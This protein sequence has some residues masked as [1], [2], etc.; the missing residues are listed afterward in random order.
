MSR[1]LGQLKEHGVVVCNAD[2][3]RLNRWAS[4][5]CPE[6]IRY[7]LDADADVQARR[8]RSLP[9]EQSLML[10]AGNSIAPLTSTLL[11]D[12][13][14][15]HMLCAAA[16][17]YSLGLELYETVCGI[18]RLERIPG[19]MQRVAI[20]HDVRVFV[21]AA[22]QPDR[23]AVA[24]HSISCDG[25]PVTCVAEVPDAATPEQLA[26]YGR[27]LERSASYVILTQSRRSIRFGQKAVWQVLDGCERP[28]AIQ[29]VPNRRAAIELAIRSSR[30]GETVLLAGWGAD[31]WTNHQTKE[32]RSD[33][34]VATELLREFAAEP[35]CPAIVIDSLD[36][37]A[38]VLRIFRGK[39]G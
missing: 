17:G 30:P 28:A 3:A 14:A 36:A 31:R 34:D 24:L 27:V 38:P 22:D 23:L 33:L 25:T 11:G 10:S 8:L 12:H 26:A 9:G 5:T 15:R 4:R 35:K 6:A 39:T 32:C 37:Q 2:D 20:D 13:N 18:E 29:I 7:G 16:V 21:D 19:R 1:L